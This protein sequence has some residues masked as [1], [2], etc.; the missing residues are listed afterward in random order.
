MAKKVVGEVKLQLVS[1]QATPNPST[2]Q[3]D[4]ER[5]ALSEAEAL[6]EAEEADPAKATPSDA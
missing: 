4:E 3:R 2:D 6:E 1:G 5:V